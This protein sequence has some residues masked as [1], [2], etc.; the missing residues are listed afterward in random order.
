MSSLV[1][2]G[3]P[4]GPSAKGSLGVYVDSNGVHRASLIGLFKPDK[5]IMIPKLRPNAPS[6][7]SIVIG[8]VMRL[9]SQQ[10]SLSITVVDGI[11][12]PHG[13]DYV[14]V[15]RQQDV[16]ATEVDRVK[17]GDCFRGGDIVKGQVIS[18]GDSRS[19]YISTARADLGVMFA[20]SE[21][22]NPME[23]MSWEEM[24]SP[25]DGTREKR[26]VARPTT[27]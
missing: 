21:A 10:A 17:L 3:Q 7:N 14:G 22:G 11:A 1:L 27:E 24:Y 12:L 5:S 4:L 2:P 18:I 23:P 25:R 8:T 19:Y 13:E 9:S 6:E 20:T 16:R 26:K 15:I